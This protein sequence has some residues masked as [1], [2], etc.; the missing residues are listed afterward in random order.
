MSVSQHQIATQHTTELAA[1][2]HTKYC[3]TNTTS[4]QHQRFGYCLDVNTMKDSLLLMIV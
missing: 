4:L 3:Q 2:S 1:D